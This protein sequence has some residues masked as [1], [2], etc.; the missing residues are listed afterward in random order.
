MDGLQSRLVLAR[1]RESLT[2][3]SA[4]GAYASPPVR[5][6]CLLRLNDINGHSG[7]GIV[8][9]GIIYPNGWVSMCWLTDT[10]SVTFYESI[11]VVKKLHG[12]D[13]ATKVIVYSLAIIEEH[14][15]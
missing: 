1:S 15:L 13:G 3:A 12:H 14:E 8:A 7:T 10:A 4:T 5:A 6:F 2:K 9:Q 11:D